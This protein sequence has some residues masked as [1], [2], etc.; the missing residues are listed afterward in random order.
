ME[1]L[2]GIRLSLD[3]IGESLKRISSSSQTESQSIENF[4]G[5]VS[6][7]FPQIQALSSQ[8]P[9]SDEGQQ[10]EPFVPPWWDDLDEPFELPEYH[11]L[12]NIQKTDILTSEATIEVMTAIEA[13]VLAEDA[14]SRE[15]IENHGDTDRRKKL[16]KV[17][18]IGNKAFDEMV[19]RNLKLVL[20]VA[21]R[22]TR[23]VP[24][25]DA[26]S[27]GVFGLM[28]AIR[29]FDWRLGH[30]FSTYATW[31]LRQ[32]ITREIAVTNTT[33]DIPVHAVD[34]VNAY[35]RD[36]REHL[37][38]EFT[39][40][41]KITV[42]DQ[43][44]GTLRV[45][46]GLP[47]PVFQPTLDATLTYAL[48]ASAFSF[49]FW[50][51]FHEAPWL[52]TDYE[53]PELAAAELEY[54]AI[55]KDLATRLTGFVLSERELEVLLNRHGA[56][57]G[58]P[59][60]L[61]E[62]GESLGVTRE[63]VRQ[64]EKK[65]ILKLNVFLEGVTIDNY[66]EEIDN[67]SR[68]YEIKCESDAS[69]RLPTIHRD[70]CGEVSG[71]WRH[72]T[73]YEEPCQACKRAHRALR[74]IDKNQGKGLSQVGPSPKSNSEGLYAAN[75][76]RR[77]KA[78]VNQV[79]QVRWAL[80]ALKSRPLSE[81]VLRTAEARLNNPNSSLSELAKT[82]GEGFTKD[83]VAGNLRRLIGMAAKELGQIPPESN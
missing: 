77:L 40:G 68:K 33:I 61:E 54:S 15:D 2:E 78:S 46:E 70:D 57:N 51:V 5:K 50:D 34:R 24:L 80:E 19:T 74:N 29:K 81:Q 83:M 76:E 13:G 56:I 9:W 20:H 1:Q 23:R 21:R 42:R 38:G 44:G 32:S 73:K 55:A 12:I 16:L 37:N 60:T 79:A 43:R 64:I 71:Y 59:R 17:V 22:Y 31:W 11:W 67:A 47:A 35:Q 58:E 72:R 8:D 10:E 14:L 63:R 4:H 45:T 66:W 82:L 75:N 39:Q 30:Q 52:L 49:D 65:A 48:E 69:L 3:E 7:I 36:L 27:F 26:F 62:I 53:T 25:E 18:E 41:G 6:A 28:Q